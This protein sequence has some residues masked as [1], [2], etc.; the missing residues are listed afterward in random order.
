MMEE[1]LE[2]ELSNSVNLKWYKSHISCESM[3][4]I[5]RHIWQCRFLIW[6]PI[7]GLKMRVRRKGGSEMSYPFTLLQGTIQGFV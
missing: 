4:I 6:Q 5:Q 2:C 1:W 3:S 7:K